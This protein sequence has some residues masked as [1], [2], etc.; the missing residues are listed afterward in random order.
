MCTIVN[1]PGGTSCHICFS[2]APASAYVDEEA[3]KLK[4]AAEEK[5]KKAEEERVA[6]EKQL[7]EERKMQEE[8]KR[9]EEEKHKE[10]VKQEFEK[11]QQF[12]EQSKVLGY[13][14]SSIR[15]GKDRRPLL[16]GAVMQHSEECVTDLHLKSLAYRKQYLAHFM[17]PPSLAGVVENRL[18][19]ERFNN[20]ADCLQ[21]LLL[22]N[23]SLLESFYPALGDHQDVHLGMN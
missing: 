20:E 14:F 22:N 23:Q 3:A 18:T 9:L 19:R 5:E 10:K 6:S 17:G 8:L 12:L 1:Q 16:V 2:Q 11:T 4:K 21:S 15:G 13:L 7:E